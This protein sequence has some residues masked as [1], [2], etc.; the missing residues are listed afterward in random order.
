MSTSIFSAAS[1]SA[2]DTNLADHVND[3]DHDDNN[4]YCQTEELLAAEGYSQ[5]ELDMPQ[6]VS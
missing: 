6:L 1:A 2:S 4:K 3:D 5:T